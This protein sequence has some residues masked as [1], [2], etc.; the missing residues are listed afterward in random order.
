MIKLTAHARERVE[1]GEV[2]QDWIVATVLQP[3]WTRPDPRRPEITLSFRAI[4]TFGGGFS[5]LR[6]GVWTPMCL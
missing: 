6:T 1:S 4:A 5:G 3:D 2:A